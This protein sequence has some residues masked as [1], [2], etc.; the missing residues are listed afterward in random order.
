MTNKAGTATRARAK[1]QNSSFPI[2]V[3]STP[4]PMKNMGR[5][6]GRAQMPEMIG[7]RPSYFFLYLREA[8]ALLVEQIDYDKSRSELWSF[9]PR[10]NHPDKAC[11]FQSCKSSRDIRLGPAGQLAQ[12]T[13]A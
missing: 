12:R 5:R 1:P 10:P 7:Q 4:S 3:T 9:R 6:I 2:P 13:H 8:S 11:F